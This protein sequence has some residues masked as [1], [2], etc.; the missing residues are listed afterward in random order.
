M[1]NKQIFFQIQWIL[2]GLLCGFYDI[3]LKRV[4]NIFPRNMYTG[5]WVF[6]LSPTTMS[7]LTC[8]IWQNT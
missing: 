4:R 3:Y 7:A 2:V 8:N 5:L 6:R 1:K